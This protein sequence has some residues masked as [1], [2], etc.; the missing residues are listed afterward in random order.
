MHL[1]SFILEIH[2]CRLLLDLSRGV[3]NMA[4]NNILLDRG[5]ILPW[6]L[7]EL[8]SLG[9]SIN[10]LHWLNN[11]RELYSLVENLKQDF[12]HEIKESEEQGLFVNPGG[13]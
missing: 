1:N 13:G 10:H 11:S 9:I 3:K 6:L 7:Q 5:G 4:S 2:Y 12:L 8:N